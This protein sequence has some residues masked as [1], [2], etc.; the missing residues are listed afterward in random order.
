MGSEIGKKRKV[1]DDKEDKE[2]DREQE[3]EQLCAWNAKLST[4]YEKRGNVLRGVLVALAKL[5]RIVARNA[6]HQ[7]A[8]RFGHYTRGS[9]GTT[10]LEYWEEGKEY[11]DIIAQLEPIQLASEKVAEDQRKLLM[12]IQKL[13]SSSNFG[14]IET[15]KLEEYQ[16]L[17]R[18]YSILQF[19]EASIKRDFAKIENQKRLH[20]QEKNIYKQEAK[21]IQQEDASPFRGFPEYHDRYVLLNLLGKGG[22]GE[23]YKAFDMEENKYV[24]CKLQ[25]LDPQIS[26]NEQLK[27]STL[28]HMKREWDVHKTLVHPHIIRHL[29]NFTIDNDTYCTVLELCNGKDLQ[30]ALKTVH[31]FAENEARVLISQILHGLA[32]LDGREGRIIHYDLK[33]ANILLADGVV[34]ISDFG[35]CKVMEVGSEALELTSPGAGTIWYLPPECLVGGANSQI[36]TK[37]DV[38]SAGVVFYEL[39]FGRVPFGF[40]AGSRDTIRQEIIDNALHFPTTP[41]VS[42]EA[43][44]FIRE[45]LTYEQAL[46]P[47]AGTLVQNPYLTLSRPN[48]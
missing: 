37:V 12:Q 3:L 42:L 30:F 2:A 7:N 10:I 40:G 18:D 39:L 21:R 43:K 1:G 35:L 31:T 34:K 22:F 13:Q 15:E 32:Y 45:C 48:V 23:V 36:S 14:K 5:E 26:K 27:A 19:H 4:D 16:N 25:L 6:L 47:S 24:A 41:E 17:V 44:A 29:D 28:R 8:S 33:P 9:L 38:W 11:N 20:E 46:R